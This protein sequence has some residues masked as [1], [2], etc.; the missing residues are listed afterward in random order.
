[1]WLTPDDSN[2]FLGVFL[3]LYVISRRLFVLLNRKPTNFHL[4][5][6]YFGEFQQ[7]VATSVWKF[8]SLSLPSSFLHNFHSVQGS[9]ALY[10]PAVSYTF[11][12]HVATRLTLSHPW[13]EIKNCCAK[14]SR[15]GPCERHGSMDVFGGIFWTQKKEAEIYF[16]SSGADNV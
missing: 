10:G 12:D 8:L 6:V 13:R 7:V 5:L 16:L 4:H 15:D 11:Q 3:G 9:A 1:M 2:L 14:A